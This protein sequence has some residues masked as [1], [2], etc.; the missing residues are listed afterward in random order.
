MEKSKRFE[1]KCLGLNEYGQGLILDNKKTVPVANLL[2]SERALIANEANGV[3]RVH[4]ILKASPNRVNPQCGIYERCG[5]CHL[6]HMNYSMQLEFKKDYVRECYK[7]YKINPKIEEIILAE[8]TTGY[9]NKMQVAFKYRENKIIY[10]FYEEGSHRLIPM[11]ECLVQTGIQL[12]ILKEIQSLMTKLRIQPYNEDKR[13]GIIRFVLIKEGFTSKELMV[14][15]ITNSEIFPARSEFLKALLTKFPQITTII[16]NVNSRKTSIILGND[17]RILY[18]NGYIEDTLLGYKFRI[19]S[20][21]FFQINPE[22]TEKLYSK[23][24][25]MAGFTGTETVIDAYSGVGTIGIILSSHV[26]RVIAVENNQQAVKAAIANAKLNGVKNVHFVCDDATPFLQE[27][28]KNKEKVDAII[29]DPP[30]SGATEKFLAA[31]KELKPQKLIYV[32]CEAA[33]QARDINFLNPDY[34]IQKMVLVD[35]FVGTYHVETIALLTR[36]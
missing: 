23:V 11:S 31:I 14:V 17:E 34:Q 8:K 7:N 6:L 9:R 28:A 18:G 24:I 19:T 21:S 32:S 27:M 4:R 2:P 15:I 20:K 29:M 16:Q 12:Q 35:L 30:R 25:A 33:T 22:Q 10:G 1:A 36:K 26:G 13:T 5:G 3:Y